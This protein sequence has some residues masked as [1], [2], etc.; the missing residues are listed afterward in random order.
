MG[1]FDTVI[2]EGLKLKTPKEVKS[3][4]RES[5]STLPTEFQT[6]DLDNCL[7]VFRIN[8]KKQLFKE[9]R[10]P[11]GRKVKYEPFTTKWTD[12]RPWLE[13]VY[14]YFKNK[15]FNLTDKNS[16]LVDETKTVT[17]KTKLTNT[18]TMLSYDEIG[19]RYLTLDY[20]VKVINGVVKSIKL[21]EYSIESKK[22]AADRHKRDEEFK[23]NV[24]INIEKQNTF[25]AKW[26]YPILRQ[27]YTPLVFFTRIIVQKICNTII[28]WSYNWTGV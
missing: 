20:E 12:S 28:K 8:S 1:M 3:F 5:D 18:F 13:K 16:R 11:T 9:E 26:Y 14:W 4:L 6:K 15:K 23:N 10:R 22:E 25:R 2:V 17:V 21:L 24:S 27:T 7:T 19:G